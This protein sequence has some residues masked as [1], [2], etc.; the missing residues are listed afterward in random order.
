MRDLNELDTEMAE[1]IRQINQRFVILQ[2]LSTDKD[3][4]AT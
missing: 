4:R 2:C 3:R 1:R